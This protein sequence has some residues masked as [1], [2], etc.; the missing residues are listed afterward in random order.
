MADRTPYSGFPDSASAQGPRFEPSPEIHVNAT[1]A[2]FGV[3]VAQSVEQ[4]GNVQEG[5]GKELFER[6]RALQE[7]HLHTDVNSRLADTQNQ[8]MNRY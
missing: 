5:A 6:A 7:L 1:P 4:L 2:A 8:M 3:N